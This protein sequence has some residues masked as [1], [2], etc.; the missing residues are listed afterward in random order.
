MVDH[1]YHFEQ[2]MR[3]AAARNRE[4]REEIAE[5]FDE[6]SKERLIRIMETKLRTAFIGALSAFEDEFREVKSDPKNRQ[7]WE[8][9]RNR[10]LDNGNAQIRMMRKELGHYDV[11]WTRNVIEFESDENG[12]LRVKKGK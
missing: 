2:Q 3:E 7:R 5:K 8:M 1:E 4:L 12:Q 6:R 10:I 9:M 11:H